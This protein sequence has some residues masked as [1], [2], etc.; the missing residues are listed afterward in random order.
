MKSIRL[1]GKFERHS[2][3]KE[4]VFAEQILGKEEFVD[5]AQRR[6]VKWER[7]DNPDKNYLNMLSVL[8]NQMEEGNSYVVRYNSLFDE[9]ERLSEVN[10]KYDELEVAKS[11]ADVLSKLERREKTFWDVDFGLRIVTLVEPLSW[12][13]YCK[14]V[15]GCDRLTSVNKSTDEYE[16][17][18]KI[19]EYAELRKIAPK[20]VLSEL[21]SSYFRR[22]MEAYAMLDLQTLVKA[23]QEL[24]ASIDKQKERVELSAI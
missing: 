5:L 17:H 14:L 10:N 2:I 12:A 23:I 13:T 1:I 3:D 20:E 7:N 9:R 18:E 24:K 21:Y 22:F 11:I 15:F 19:I 8:K 6:G 16:Y 4:I